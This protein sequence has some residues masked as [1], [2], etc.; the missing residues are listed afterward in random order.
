M[1]SGPPRPSIAVSKLPTRPL[2]LPPAICLF[3]VKESTTVRWVRFTYISTPGCRR[4]SQATFHPLS[5]AC[6]MTRCFP[7]LAAP[8]SFE[9]PVD[10][11]AP[12]G[13]VHVR[14]SWNITDRPISV[15]VPSLYP[16]A[17]RSF[18]SRI[19]R[20]RPI[21]LLHPVSDQFHPLVMECFHELTTTSRTVICNWWSSA[22]GGL[23]RH[24]ETPRAVFYFY[25]MRAYA[26][27]MLDRLE[28]APR[29]SVTSRGC[30]RN[31]PR[32]RPPR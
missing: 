25:A 21:R 27:I 11:Q 20:N 4:T 2:P 32:H 6:S 30:T 23:E 26:S 16:A 18:R 15:S 12:R 10:H 14:V 22:H 7:G 29:T 28:V 1:T 31:R 8:I 9:R 24:P 3:P 19:P 5:N 17:R 13:E